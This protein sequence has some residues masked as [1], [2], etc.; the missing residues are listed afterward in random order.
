[1]AITTSPDVALGRK[2][3][4]LTV[5]TPEDKDPKSVV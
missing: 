2:G 3:R 5:W 4:T 1:M